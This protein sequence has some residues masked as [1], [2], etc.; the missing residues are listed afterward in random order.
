MVEPERRTL[1]PA[2]V[3]TTED[4]SGCILAESGRAFVSL[5]I[6]L[7]QIDGLNHNAVVV[8]PG[9]ASSRPSDSCQVWSTVKRAAGVHYS[10]KTPGCDGQLDPEEAA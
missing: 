2:N 4:L 6:R 10:I 8:R 7:K 9:R 5:A 1:I 3:D